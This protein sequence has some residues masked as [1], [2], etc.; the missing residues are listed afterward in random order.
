MVCRAE[1]AVNSPIGRGG[2]RPFAHPIPQFS[3]AHFRLLSSS[4]E[5]HQ[6]PFGTIQQFLYCYCGSRHLTVHLNAA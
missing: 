5:M 2:R 3:G 1:Q 6:T 4:K